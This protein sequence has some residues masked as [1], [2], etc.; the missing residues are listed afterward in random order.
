MN[1]AAKMRLYEEVRATIDEH[2]GIIERPL[3]AAL[4]LA[5]AL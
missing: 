4:F 2:G 1:P 3:L 5:A